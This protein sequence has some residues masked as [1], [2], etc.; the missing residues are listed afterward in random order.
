MAHGKVN[1]MRRYISIASV[2]VIIYLVY[3][4]FFSNNSVMQKIEYQRQIDSLRRELAATRDS[5]DYYHR[6]NVG[7]ASD[8]RAIE[9]VVRE[10]HNMNRPGED[11][12]LM[13]R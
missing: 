8:P 7:L 6:L 10:E 11:V 4:F 12:Y 2:L 9:Q 13:T 1:W 3:L 5:V